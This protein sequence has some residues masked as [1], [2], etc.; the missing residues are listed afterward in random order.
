[1]PRTVASGAGGCPGVD[2]DD[3]AGH[4]DETETMI[5]IT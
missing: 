2:D 4:G 3:E 5:L 1:M